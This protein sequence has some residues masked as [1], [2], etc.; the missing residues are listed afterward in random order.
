PYFFSG[1][2][3]V[4]WSASWSFRKLIV[5]RKWDEHRQPE[6]HRYV[7]G[8]GGAL[9]QPSIRVQALIWGY[10]RAIFEAFEKRIVAYLAEDSEPAAQENSNPDPEIECNARL[11][12]E[13]PDRRIENRNGPG[14]QEPDAADDIGIPLKDVLTEHGEL[15]VD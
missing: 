14:P 4:R 11:E 1:K 3:P 12:A 15:A 9:L 7:V 6:V 8:E 10:G 2:P 5:K 13:I